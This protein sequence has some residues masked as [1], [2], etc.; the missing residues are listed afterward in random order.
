MSMKSY[1][2]QG[3]DGFQ[4][5]FFKMFWNDVGNDLWHFV[6]RAF[7]M[8]SFDAATT[9]TLLVLIPKGDHPTSF[10]NFRPISLCN[11]T[12]KIIYK[13]L[14][15]RLRPFL[16]DIILP[17]QSSF[18]PGRSTKDN[19]IILQEIIYHMNKKKKKKGDMVFKLDLEKAYDKVDWGFLKQTLFMFG[20]PTSIISLIMHN[21][22]STSISL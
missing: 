11:V 14:V 17:L 6:K 3:P 9:D 5:I 13:V 4:P 1:K 2:A 15:T 21:L 22:A 12:Y 18:I 16:N 19:A 10:T 20:F 8:G 7:E